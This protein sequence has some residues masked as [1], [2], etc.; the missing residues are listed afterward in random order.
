MIINRDH[1]RQ[2]KGIRIKYKIY[3]CIHY[4]T[5]RIILVSIVSVVMVVR[6]SGLC[7]DIDCGGMGHDI[8]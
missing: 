5:T 6:P 8:V 3:I 1:K 4:I 7:G 2:R